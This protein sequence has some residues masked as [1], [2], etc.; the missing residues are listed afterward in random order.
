MGIS[1]SLGKSSSPAFP[2]CTPRADFC[3]R[4]GCGEAGVPPGFYI[5]LQA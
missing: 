1:V 3:C 2:R 4:E 5:V